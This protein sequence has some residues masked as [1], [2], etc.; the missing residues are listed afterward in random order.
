MLDGNEL[1]FGDLLVE[2]GKESHSL[3]IFLTYVESRSNVKLLRIPSDIYIPSVP[4]WKPDYESF[5]DSRYVHD[6]GFYRSILNMNYA[7]PDLIKAHNDKT[8]HY[9]N[10]GKWLYNCNLYPLDK[11]SKMKKYFED[12]PD[13]QIFIPNW[14]FDCG[15]SYYKELINSVYGCKKSQHDD[16]LDAVRYA[17]EEFE[18]RQREE[19]LEKAKLTNEELKEM[20]NNSRYGVCWPSELIES[21]E[22]IDKYRKEE[23]SMVRE[24]RCTYTKDHN[25]TGKIIAGGDT[26]Y[27]IGDYGVEPEDD[28]EGPVYK[29]KHLYAYKVPKY[30]DADTIAK[31]AKLYSRDQLK[32]MYYECRLSYYV[33]WSDDKVVIPGGFIFVNSNKEDACSG[34]FVFT[35]KKEETKDMSRNEVLKNIVGSDIY[36]KKH[37]NIM[38]VGKGQS[39]GFDICMDELTGN[40]SFVADDEPLED[41]P[42]KISRSFI[43]KVI[44]NKPATIVFWRDGSKTVVKMNGKDKKFDP[45]KGLAMAIAKKCL[46]NKGN[47][48]NTF[49]KFLPEEKV[50]KKS[51]KK[52]DKNE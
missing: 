6:H 38:Y 31:H 25:L 49:T 15:N 52:G 48:Y 17:I 20:L 41:E 18:I 1:K 21:C 40:I 9:L 51:A 35:K 4:V 12:H 27:V 33:Y 37:D 39:L 19:R 44:F 10:L 24:N 43:K 50:G 16:M 34:G 36:I 28:Y 26:Y 47:Y 46:G 11:R 8:N 2:K 45:E 30:F 7:D 23:E 32:G 13:A 5:L 3:F 22:R 14:H 29:I 42:R